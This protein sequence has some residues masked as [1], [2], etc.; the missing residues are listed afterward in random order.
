MRNWKGSSSAIRHG[1]DSYRLS[2]SWKINF[3]SGE[4]EAAKA[5]SLCNSLGFRNPHITLGARL[6]TAVHSFVLNHLILQN[7]TNGAAIPTF[8]L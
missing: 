8:A 1:K 6:C 7:K 5:I 4:L 3:G 2:A